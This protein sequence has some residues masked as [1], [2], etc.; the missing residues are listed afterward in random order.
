MPAPDGF[1]SDVQPAAVQAGSQELVPVVPAEPV[2][3]VVQADSQER[4]P[5][6]LAELV[7]A[8]L[9]ALDYSPGAC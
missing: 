6:V 3:A 1:R 5:V 8:A 7:E 2:E 9:Q 4:G